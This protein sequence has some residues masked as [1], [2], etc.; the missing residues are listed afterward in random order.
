[1]PTPTPDP[2]SS[3]SDPA[4]ST[5]IG[6][7]GT[8]IIADSEDAC[9][10]GQGEPPDVAADVSP[11]Q[12][13]ELINSGI[14]ISDKSGNV[15]AGYPESLNTFW[16]ANSPP[17]GDFLTDTQVAYDPF[18][19]TW[20]VTTLAVP[21][22]KDNGDLYVAFSK[23]SDAT[24]GWNYY[25]L[26]NVC[27]STQN[28]QWP[29]PDQPVVGYNQTWAAIDLQCKGIGGIG[30]GSDQLVLLPG[31]V[32]TQV[33]APSSLSATVVTPP[34]FGSRPSRD[35]SGGAGQP[36]FL[37]TSA[38]PSG[39]SLPYIEL[40]TVD[41]SANLT[42]AANSPGNGVAGTYGNFA[43]AQHDSC[44]AGSACAV[45]LQ[46]AR[47]T[48][49]T[50][51][52]GNDG[53]TYLLT[54][55]HAG[56][57]G[58]GTTQA[59]WF[60]DQLTSGTWNEFYVDGPGWWAGY[61]TITMDSD[62][63]I[64]FTFQSFFY[65]SNIY[66]NWYIAK[67]FNSSGTGGPPLLGYGIVPNSY[68]GAYAGCAGLSP[69]R[70]GDYMSTLWDPNLPAPAGSNGFWTVQ[71]YS[72]GGGAQTGSNQSTQI[73]ELAS[74]LPYYVSYSAHEQE[75]N[76]GAGNTCTAK[77]TT[78]SGLKN[79]D[80]VIA[81]LDMGGSFQKPPA[82]PDKTWVELPIANEGNA[83]SMVVGACGTHDLGTAY[84]YAHVYGSSN[85]TGT[86][87]FNHVI[88]YFCNNVLP[89]IEGFVVGYRGASGSLNNYV[90][91]GYQSSSPTFHVV[92]G[93][94]PA[95]SPSDGVLLNVFYGSGS[96]SP[97]SGEGSTSFT[98]PGFGSPASAVETPLSGVI[99]SYLLTDV[100][101]PAT[102][103]AMNQYFSNSSVGQFDVFGWQVFVPSAN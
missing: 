44:G 14:W 1:M 103:T 93:P 48:S 52:K 18:A 5:P 45:S 28:G 17:S 31:S 34:V 12:I 101:L 66:P 88:N 38:V 68:R 70:W 30:S 99:S 43:A 11:T 54:S 74:P 77:F 16:A 102:G 19:L 63:G 55:F 24:A 83:T 78:P 4:G 75:C 29:V 67:G 72:N 69:T 100:G 27:S 80:I 13:V 26:V 39:S 98:L 76:V 62:L 73:T 37:A 10:T 59:L 58:N 60:V 49:A 64:A 90:L 65:G 20:V 86:Y 33:P 46:D 7:Y 36:L 41:S 6:P 35:I 2:Q 82:P 15:A 96:E 87:K 9:V 89:E 84:A 8:P 92:V 21:N 51:Q 57:A 91:Y 61:P 71:E 25:K 81:F 95:N 32:L 79:G 50:I 97:E 85:E 53:N 56:D 47:I 3:L 23:S 22:T 42:F 40:Y 94:A